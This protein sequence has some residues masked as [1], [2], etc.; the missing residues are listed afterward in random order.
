M[1]Q[2]CDMPLDP[3]FTLSSLAPSFSGASLE[4]LSCPPSLAG[5]VSE[6]TGG[7]AEEVTKRK[8]PAHL[9]RSVNDPPRLPPIDPDVGEGSSWAWAGLRAFSRV[10]D[11]C[12]GTLGP[13][14]PAV[15]NFLACVELTEEV[16]GSNGEY[17]Q[18]KQDL[19]GIF[20]DLVGYFGQGIPP[21]MRPSIRNI[22]ESLKKEIASIQR[23]QARTTATRMLTSFGDPDEI[24]NSYRR[25]QTY[26]TRLGLNASV[27]TWMLIDE[28]ITISRLK[29]LS[30]ALSARYNSAESESIYRSECTPETRVE[31]LAR[32]QAW[33][34]SVD[35]E[36]I[37]WLNGMAG[38][39]KTTLSYTF[40]RILE[41][42]N[43]L[44]ANFFCSRQIKYCGEVH[45]IIPSIAYELA[46][47]SYPFRCALSEV[48]QKHHDLE[49]QK[50]S[51][52]FAKLLLEPLQ[53]VATSLQRNL[54]IVIE[55]LDECEN[56]QGVG[57]LLD[58]ILEN[59]QTMPVRFFLTSRPEPVIRN[60]MLRRSGDREQF[61]LHLHELDHTMVGEDIKRYLRVGLKPARV[62][63][64]Q[65]DI[66]AESSGVLFIYAATVVRYISA[67]NFE[68]SAP[69]LKK[70]LDVPATGTS[71]LKHIN[72]LYRLILEEAFTDEL[73]TVEKDEMR[74]V[75]HTVICAQEPLT[76]PVI[77]RLLGKDEEEC[78]QPS[79]SPLRS[80]LNIEKKGNKVTTLHKSFPDY[81]L[82]KT[83]SDQFYCDSQA[84][85]AHM[86]E[87]SLYLIKGIEPLFNVCELELSRRPDS[88]VPGIAATI[89]NRIPAWL[90][91]ACR[92]WSTHF[93]KAG[94][95]ATQLF[96]EVHLLMSTRLLTWME[97]MNLTGHLRSEGVQIMS[98]LRE[99]MGVGIIDI[100]SYNWTDMW[101]E[102]EEYRDSLELLQDAC[103]FI[104]TYCG[105]P[106][107][108]STPQIYMHTL[109]FWP[110]E[111]PVSKYYHEQVR[112]SMDHKRD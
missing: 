103:D 102:E 105:S 15:D 111:K 46:Q 81:I 93:L 112:R 5:T 9:G 40:C 37:Y 14:K 76:V 33:C 104:E 91:Y 22:A 27:N 82:D 19:N 20:H 83:R 18:L 95:S 16:L 107:Y 86:A 110:K 42:G 24:L 7:E 84:H 80:V 13:L 72:S 53:Q 48:I 85:H 75:L 17:Q 100:I 68:R 36:K 1:A 51:E 29:S 73:E 59:A 34:T 58:M 97:V 50:L 77:A 65:L 4:V 88:A 71:D 31:A 26:F 56:Q 2:R 94:Q 106:G 41:D 45:R 54:V 70:I 61:E 35:T 6:R 10:L 109:A 108:P 69:R 90:V 60:R 87:R 23:K 38:T 11:R 57:E 101:E 98:E 43:Q 99:R 21:G 39:G 62:T 8:I 32:F 52:Q 67:Q 66:L 92:R 63:E 47:Y 89:D 3:P 25:M 78:V 74:L 79:L 55:A 44:A 12:G 96:C 30:P 49:T 28:Q 64:E